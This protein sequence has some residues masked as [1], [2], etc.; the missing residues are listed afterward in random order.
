MSLLRKMTYKD[1]SSLNTARSV[2]EETHRN[3]NGHRNGHR[4]GNGHRNGHRHEKQNPN[5]SHET[6]VL[7]LFSLEI[8]KRAIKR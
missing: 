7:R 8:L 4:H 5:R 3:E 1:N 2:E 6:I